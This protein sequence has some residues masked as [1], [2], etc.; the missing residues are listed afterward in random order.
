[1]SFLGG[2]VGR[3]QAFPH[4]GGSLERM[5]KNLTPPTAG[6]SALASGISA[7]GIREAGAAAQGIGVAVG[8]ESLKEREASP[9][10]TV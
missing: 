10:Q 1:M 3:F 9:C 5:L 8:G 7:E 2:R 6:R 4:P